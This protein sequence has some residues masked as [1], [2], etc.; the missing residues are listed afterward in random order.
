MLTYVVYVF[1]FFFFSS[2]RRH[3][4]FDCDWSSDVCSS[5]LSMRPARVV[6]A[7]RAMTRAAS[8]QVAS[9]AL[10]QS[11]SGSDMLESRRSALQERQVEVLRAGTLD[12]ALVAGVRVPHDAAR[13]IVPQH[14]LEPARG[15]RRAVAHDDDAGVLRAADTDA[16]AVI[17]RH[18][19]RSAGGAVRP[20][21]PRAERPGI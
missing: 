20:V 9:C 15:G 8:S 12:R 21:V 16:A 13:R 14:A 19:C 11:L 6:S 7:P 10:R 5:D 3:T 17:D 4:R 2:R 18:P 1:F